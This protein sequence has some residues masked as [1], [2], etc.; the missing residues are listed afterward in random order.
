[1]TTSLEVISPGMYTLLVDHGRPRTRSLGVPVSGAADRFSL[2][3]GNALVGNE[4][5]T[6]ALEISSGGVVLRTDGPLACSLVGAPFDARIGRGSVRANSCFPLKTGDEL[7]ISGTRSGA[8]A[9]LCIRHGI[10]APLI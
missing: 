1:M 8:R 9:Y 4:P 5:D 3:I 10:D 7:A 2:A 6:A